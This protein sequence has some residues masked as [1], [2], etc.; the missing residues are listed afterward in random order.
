MPL[1]RPALRLTAAGLLTAALTACGGARPY[2]SPVHQRG[3]DLNRKAA[4]AASEG[5]Y[6]AAVN[7]YR[8]ALEVSRSIENVEAMAANLLGL[9]AVQRSAGRRDE[10]SKSLEEIMAAGPVAYPDGLRAEAALIK[11]LLFLDA[12]D[13]LQGGEWAGRA[14][15]LCRASSCGREGRIGNVMA[16]A[17]IMGGDAAA[18]R[19]LAQEALGKNRAAADLEESANSLRLMAQAEEAQGRF[20]DA[21]G[22]F[23]EAMVIDKKLGLPDKLAADLMGL[24]RSRLGLDSR[25]EALAFFRRAFSVCRASGDKQGMEAAAAMIQRLAP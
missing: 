19:T 16:L 25:E 15:A 7:L 11:S 3:L 12:G 20:D 4:A 1:P 6:D 8:Q 17:A 24:G 21:A 2:V 9:A 13:R 18:A 14:M 10:S 22:H 5:Q 23:G